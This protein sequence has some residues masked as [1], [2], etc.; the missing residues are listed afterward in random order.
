M[1][2]ASFQRAGF[3]LACLVCLALFFTSSPANAA[4]KIPVDL[5]IDV[6]GA[7]A[8]D[9]GHQIE[10]YF[11]ASDFY[12]LD[13]KRAPRIAIS[14]NAASKKDSPIVTYALVLSV[15]T[16]KCPQAF[17]GVIFGDT[18]D[19]EPKALHDKLEKAIMAIAKQF[20]L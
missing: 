20:N 6:T 16:A 15:V 14:V 5:E 12:A 11:R 3:A 17:A 9:F 8:E 13:K 7:T 18:T 4:T 1:S 2:Y 10:K 19:E